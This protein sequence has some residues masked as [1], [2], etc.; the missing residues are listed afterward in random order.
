MQKY[1]LCEGIQIDSFTDG[2]AVVYDANQEMIHILNVTA[3]MVLKSISGFLPRGGQKMMK[4]Y[5]A[6]SAE[7]KIVCL[8]T[9]IIVN[10][11]YCEYN[12][13][14]GYFSYEIYADY[15]DCVQDETVTKWCKADNPREAFYEDMADWYM[16]SIWQC[17]D[18]V[19][20]TV[21]DNWI[22]DEFSYEEY[23]NFIEDWIKEHLAVNL[24]YDHYLKQPVCVDIIVDTGDENYDYV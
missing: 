20:E 23:Q 22:S 16:E 10:K 18:N 11:T 21:R 2:E 5:N 7:E 9:D 13:E 12:K 15:R 24:P 4:S 1:K 8:I 17:E 19:I 14:K 6:L 3:T